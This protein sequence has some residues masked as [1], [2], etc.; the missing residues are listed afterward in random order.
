MNPPKR[1]PKYQI[2]KSC[3]RVF[4]DCNWHYGRH[5]CPPP[6]NSHPVALVLW[7]VTSGVFVQAAV[8]LKTDNKESSAFG[9]FPREP[10]PSHK[11][12]ILSFPILQGSL[13]WEWH[14]S[15][16]YGNGSPTTG[17]HGI[18]LARE[19]IPIDTYPIHL[20]KASC[21][22][23]RLMTLTG[24]TSLDDAIGMEFGIESLYPHEGSL[25]NRRLHS[26]LFWYHMS[27]LHVIS[28]IFRDPQ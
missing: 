5:L 18:S 1:L 9:N 15:N 8:Q 4:L 7:R 13:M 3:H 17:V 28:G 27:Y 23:K 2:Y 12:P 10:Q 20:C 21:D 11:L 16:D 19:E 25:A 22:W 24:V 14:G 26:L 6:P